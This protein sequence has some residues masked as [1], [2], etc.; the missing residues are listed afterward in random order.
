MTHDDEQRQLTAAR[1]DLVREFSGRLDADAVG[2]RFT[3]V[4]AGFDGAPIRTFVPVLA[5]R[6][7]RQE[8]AGRP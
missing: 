6:L 5:Q 7:V 2:R 4:V 1:E 3:Q 8:L